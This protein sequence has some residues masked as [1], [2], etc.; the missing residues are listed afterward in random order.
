MS[1]LIPREHSFIFSSDSDNGADNVSLDGSSFSVV[2]STSL[3]I[4]K[5]AMYCYLS[6]T[7]ANIWNTSPNISSD[8]ANNQFEF[9]T[10]DVG[11]PGTHTLTIS[12]GL[13]SVA[14][15]NGFLSTSF[16]NLSLPANLITLTGDSATGKSVLT[17]L[18]AG[19][20]VDFTI[21]DS[22]R[23]VLGF[24]SRISPV[25]PQIAGYSDYSDNVASF[26]RVNSYIITSNIVSN[27]IPLNGG[28]GGIIASVPID[29]APGSQIAYS[30][31]NPI[32]IDASELIGHSKLNLNFQLRDQLRRLTPTSNETWSVVVSIKY[33]ILLTTDRV[34]MMSF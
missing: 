20:S 30:P 13:Y 10:T 9:T 22:V 21:N 32:S 23:E 5:A 15:L 33:G 3:Q 17:F 2:L 28:G 31:D 4:P 34:K 24:S 12:D 11:N 16:T 1:T 7:Q 19:D 29:V 18:T 6:V 25:A 14:A 27:G 26:N 8:F